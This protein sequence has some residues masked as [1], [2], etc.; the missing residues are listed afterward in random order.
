M[1]EKNNQM[2]EN[3]EEIKKEIEDLPKTLIIFYLIVFIGAFYFLM[4]QCY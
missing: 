3:N 1:D 4:R 2:I